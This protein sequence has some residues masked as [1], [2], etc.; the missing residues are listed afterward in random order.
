M[1]NLTIEKKPA[2]S[3][4]QVRTGGELF[5]RILQQDEVPFVFG[6][7]G[8]GMAEIQDAMVMVKPPKWIMGLHE[9]TTVNAAAGYALASESLGQP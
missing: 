2:A 4:S 9:F 8:A 3:E 7:T 1:Q 6:T 5:M